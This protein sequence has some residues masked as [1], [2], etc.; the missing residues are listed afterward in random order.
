LGGGNWEV[1]LLSDDG[2]S[3]DHGKKYQDKKTERPFNER[4]FYGE[5]VTFSI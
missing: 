5:F 2:G 3:L 4:Y 1:Q